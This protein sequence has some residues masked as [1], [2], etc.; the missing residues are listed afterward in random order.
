M[1]DQIGIRPVRPEG[2]EA[3]HVIHLRPSVL[4]G[5]LA[6][7]SDRLAD[8]RSRLERIDPDDHRFVAEAGGLAVGLAGL[9]VGRGK[10]RHAGEIGMMVDEVWQGRGVG[11]LLV[12]A[13]PELT[14]GWLG[15]TRVELEVVAD[16]GRAVRLYE[17]HVFKTAGRTRRAIRRP[18]GLADLLVMARLR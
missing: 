17:R 7:P 3:L 13:L 12:A 8:L 9:Q 18:G 5:T 16:N 6:L 2:A 10:T 15:L 1:D 14:D 11:G 4:A